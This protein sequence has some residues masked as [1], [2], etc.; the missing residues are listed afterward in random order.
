MGT[1]RTCNEAAA[2]RASVRASVWVRG[3][4]RVRGRSTTRT[5]PQSLSQH[6]RQHQ[7]VC[8]TPEGRTSEIEGGVGSLGSKKSGGPSQLARGHF[9]VRGSRLRASFFSICSFHQGR[10][11][12]LRA[13]S[14][15]KCSFAFSYNISAVGRTS[16]MA[17]SRKLLWPPR[18]YT[19]A[20]CLAGG[21]WRDPPIAHNEECGSKRR[22][23]A[24][25]LRGH[26][27]SRLTLRR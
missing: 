26:S 5:Q 24:A 25:S 20:R 6:H 19:T 23:L 13:P 16:A 27:D 8:C 11:S 21:E 2:R 1:A 17:V 15:G 18:T 4:S 12:T 7:T 3:N 10:L 14:A 9:S 22:N